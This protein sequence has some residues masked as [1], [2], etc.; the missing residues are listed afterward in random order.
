MPAIT[1]IAVIKITAAADGK[2]LPEGWRYCG[3]LMSVRQRLRGIV[4]AL[5]DASDCACDGGN[6]ALEFESVIFVVLNIVLVR[7]QSHLV[8]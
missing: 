6:A 7:V 5:V 2:R 3:S 4:K 8:G 1:S